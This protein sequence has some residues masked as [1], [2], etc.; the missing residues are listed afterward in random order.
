MCLTRGTAPRRAGCDITIQR[1]LVERGFLDFGRSPHPKGGN[2]RLLFV[3]LHTGGRVRGCLASERALDCLWR[4]RQ[5]AS[6]PCA[7]DAM[8]T[9]KASHVTATRVECCCQPQLRSWQ[10]ETG[11]L[12]VRVAEFGLEMIM[13]V[14]GACG[15]LSLSKEVALRGAR[16]SMV[17]FRVAEPASSAWF[18]GHYHIWKK[19][20]FVRHQQ[21]EG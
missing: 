15:V 9:A 12:L 5:L 20:G 13:A 2:V 1:T 17:A 21:H 7:R 18:L 6:C 10:F 11:F 8:L 16:F 14:C 4:T 3:S 19:C